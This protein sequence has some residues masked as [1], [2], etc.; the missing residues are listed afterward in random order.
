MAFHPSQVYQLTGDRLR[1]LCA[2]VGVDSGGT[3]RVLRQRLVEFLRADVG[4]D[5][6]EPTMDQATQADVKGVIV[7]PPRRPK[8]R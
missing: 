7:N 8:V 2:T 1:E 6:E 5:C 3:L 4:S